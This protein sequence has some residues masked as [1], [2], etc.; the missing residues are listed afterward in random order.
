MST[1]VIRRVNKPKE[2]VLEQQQTNTVEETKKVITSESGDVM[3]VYREENLLGKFMEVIE[4]GTYPK[5]KRQYFKIK[6]QGLN[7]NEEPLMKDG[8]PF[9][10]IGAFLVS[11]YDDIDDYYDENDEII[12]NEE[13][14]FSVRARKVKY[15]GDKYENKETIWMY[16]LFNRTDLT[17]DDDADNY[18]D[19]LHK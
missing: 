4:E 3:V 6:F 16:D 12:F 2:E 10:Q 1:R 11:Q 17:S 9:I 13:D 15:K 14:I 8:K 19:L 5:S 18:M 7:M